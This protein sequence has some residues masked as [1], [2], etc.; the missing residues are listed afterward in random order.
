MQNEY[1]YG[2]NAVQQHVRVE[3]S[4]SDYEPLE[5]RQA[6]LSQ[7]SSTAKI[8]DNCWIIDL[9]EQDMNHS[10]KYRKI[11]FE[12]MADYPLFMNDAKG[13]V[14]DQLM[15][16]RKIKGIKFDLG[17]IMR[18]ALPVTGDK[19]AIDYNEEDLTRI[20]DAIMKNA[21]TPGTVV[22][23]WSSI[24]NF[25]YSLGYTHICAIMEMFVMPKYIPGKCADKYIPD[26]V[27]EKMD[28]AFI[29]DDLFP[30]THRCVY[31][32][33]RCFS[34]RLEEVMA[35]PAEGVKPLP[36]GNYIITI[37]VNKTT[38]NIDRVSPR[39]F[40]IK[41]EGMG[42]F[43]IEL[44]KQQMAFTKENCPDA[45]FLLYTGRYQYRKTVDGFRYIKLNSSKVYLMSNEHIQKFLYELGP[46]LDLRDENGNPYAI[47]SHKFR[48]TVISKEINSGIF[49]PLDVMYDTEHRSGAMI[50]KNY[51]H[52]KTDTRP[53]AFHGRI[54]GSNSRRIAKLL[55]RPYVKEVYQLGICS[56]IHE[57][58]H[59]RAA[60]L[61]CEHLVPDAAN[62][63]YFNNEKQ[64]WQ[65][66]HDKAVKTGN[67]AYTELCADWVEA[68][69]AAIS[70][71][72]DVMKENENGTAE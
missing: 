64:I 34:T 33:L 44:I 21:D 23:Q 70:R 30:L 17:L 25:F 5:N 69:D 22:P 52:R 12:K 65:D 42:H 28:A 36:N 32:T 57:C 63:P 14:L 56:D 29:R 2:S 9:V 15:D 39:V 13:W 45:R 10:M 72:N 26:C 37:P 68:Y 35:I 48:H 8:E 59:T 19:R 38:G 27:L 49:R 54:V 41:N 16:G 6:C 3:V 18:I 31:W 58:D 43:Y 24:K 53:V 7:Y 40:E 4:G 46:R 62:L 1:I 67:I 55:E 20:H 11:S 47:S 66:K 61:R 71:I 50:T 60:C 51:Y